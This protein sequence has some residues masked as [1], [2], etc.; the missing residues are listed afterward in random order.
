[1]VQS[2]LSFSTQPTCM[3]NQGSMQKTPATDEQMDR[4][5]GPVPD[6]STWADRRSTNPME[7]NVLDNKGTEPRG[8]HY[9]KFYPTQGYF[10]CKKCGNPLYSAVAKFA[11]GCGWPAF[12]KCYKNAIDAVMETDGSRRIE[13]KCKKCGGHMGH[14]F[15]G[16]GFTTRGGEQTNER[17]CVNSTIPPSLT[18]PIIQ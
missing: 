8:G 12:D 1:M 3:G 17:H 11:S 4:M 15:E 14:V 9:D 10:A 7:A 18:I 16:E 2:A 5:N 6:Q 13:I